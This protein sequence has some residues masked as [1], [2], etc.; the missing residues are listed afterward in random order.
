M[1][2][3]AKM[4]RDDALKGKVIVVTGGGSGLGKAMTQYFLELGAINPRSPSNLPAT[5]TSAMIRAAPDEPTRIQRLVGGSSRRSICA[6][7]ATAASEAITT[8]GRP[9]GRF[10]RNGPASGCTGRLEKGL[11]LCCIPHC[12]PLEREPPLLH[13]DPLSAVLRSPYPSSPPP[14]MSACF[15]TEI[16]YFK[17]NFTIALFNTAN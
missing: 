2:F 8:V 17:F 12:S 5:T 15:R 9:E 6:S 16:K 7:V 1:N 4:L 10:C 14:L 11:R 13:G 3:S